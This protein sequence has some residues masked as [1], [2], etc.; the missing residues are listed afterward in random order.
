LR[1]HEILENA[2]RFQISGQ[3]DFGSGTTLAATAAGIAVTRAQLKM[4]QPLLA[5]R[6]PDLPALDTWLNR[7]QK[8]I[9]A[10]KTSRGWTPASDLTTTQREMIDAAAGQTL[11]LLSPLPVIF[12]AERLIP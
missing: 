10:E 9:D 1:T 4:L 11:E 3:A 2:M 8:L 12:E 6:Y 5:G 7:L